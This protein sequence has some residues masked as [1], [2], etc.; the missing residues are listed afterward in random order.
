MANA[1]MLRARARAAST[2]IR[3]DFTRAISRLSITDLETLEDGNIYRFVTNAI[4]SHLFG[5]SASRARHEACVDNLRD[6]LNTEQLQLIRAVEDLLA[7]QF[8]DTNEIALGDLDYVISRACREAD[9]L[10]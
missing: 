9:P 2:E 1:T 7:V 5:I 8:R 6:T 4:H 3:V 10:V